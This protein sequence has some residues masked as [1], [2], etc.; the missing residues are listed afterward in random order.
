MIMGTRKGATTL[1]STWTSGMFTT[2]SLNKVCGTS[3][4]WSIITSGVSTALS[5]NGTTRKSITASMNCSYGTTTVRQSTFFRSPFALTILQGKAQQFNAFV[6]SWVIGVKGTSKRAGHVCLFGIRKGAGN[7]LIKTRTGGFSFVQARTQ[8]LCLEAHQM[9]LFASAWVVGAVG[10][11]SKALQFFR[12]T[13]NLRGRESPRPTCS[14]LHPI[15]L[16][17]HLSAHSKE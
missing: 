14:L 5:M 12:A 4:G 1:T 10:P 2:L 17:G 7:L 16:L 6:E 9:D 8:K 11:Q 15:E 13:S 3:T